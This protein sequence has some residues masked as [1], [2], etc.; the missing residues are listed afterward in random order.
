MSAN[1]Y[2]KDL[3][4]WSYENAS[5]LRQGK[6][7]DADIQHIAEE[8]ESLGASEKNALKSHLAVLI[9]H[10]L[11]W[12]YQPNR[13]SRSW[14]LTIAN[15]RDDVKDVLEDNP[16]LKSKVDDI[17]IKAYRKAHR[18]AQKETGFSA[19]VF[20]ATCPYTFEQLLDEEFFPIQGN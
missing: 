20:P 6:F 12:E 15:Q 7:K 11:K 4:A 2:D 16:S 3:Y 13:Q 17:L 5:L 18:E 14:S 9:M 19:N 1:D 8:L 10:L